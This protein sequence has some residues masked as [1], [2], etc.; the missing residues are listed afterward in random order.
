MKR[1]RLNATAG[2][3][4]TGDLKVAVEAM[5]FRERRSMSQMLGILVEEAVAIRARTPTQQAAE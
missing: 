4:L 2:L 3:R 1:I 5:A